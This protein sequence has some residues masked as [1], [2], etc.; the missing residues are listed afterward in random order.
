MDI[1]G[2][3]YM[4]IISG[5]LRV[6]P[7]QSLLWIN[8]S[9]SFICLIFSDSHFLIF[10]WLCTSLGHEQLPSGGSFLKLLHQFI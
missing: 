7:K 6:N 5:N 3:S 10:T 1:V 8:K 9:Q 2:R 4:L